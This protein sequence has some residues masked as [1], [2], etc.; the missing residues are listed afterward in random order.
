MRSPE[1]EATE[2]GNLLRDKGDCD[3]AI[4]AYTEVIRLNPR[5]AQAFSSR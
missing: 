2:Q 5:N 1:D 4:A 3:G